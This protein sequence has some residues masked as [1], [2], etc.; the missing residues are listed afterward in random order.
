MVLVSDICNS[1]ANSLRSVSFMMPALNGLNLCILSLLIARQGDSVSRR[2]TCSAPVTSLSAPM[3][4]SLSVTYVA[5][6]TCSTSS[7][8]KRT[9]Q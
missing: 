6:Y 3:T 2:S 1:S 4:S 5:C 7:T 8:K 9:M